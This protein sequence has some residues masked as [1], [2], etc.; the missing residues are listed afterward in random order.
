M[1]VNKFQKCFHTLGMRA[2]KIY[3][4]EFYI[5]RTKGPPKR[6]V[7]AA[8]DGKTAEELAWAYMYVHNILRSIS[9]L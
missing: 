7:L 6:I 4:V 5:G 1:Y 2:A 3:Y 9:E 8:F